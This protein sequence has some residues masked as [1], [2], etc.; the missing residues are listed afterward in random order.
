[1]SLYDYAGGDPVNYLD[2][3]G[4]LVAK[5]AGM[6]I[7]MHESML[8]DGVD[9]VAGASQLSAI[10]RALQNPF[11]I[12]GLGET[13]GGIGQVRDEANAAITSGADRLGNAIG[14]DIYSD[15]AAYVGAGTHVATAIAS[16]VAPVAAEAKAAGGLGNL[17]GNVTKGLSGFLTGVFGGGGVKP[18]PIPATPPPLPSVAAKEG[19]QIFRVVN[20]VE[21]KSIQNSGKFEFLPTGS[22]PTGQPG[23]FFWSSADEAAQFQQYWYRGGENSQV[24]STTIGGQ[25]KPSLFPN[26]DGIGTAIW[27]DLKDLSAPI[28]LPK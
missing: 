12:P 24:I 15:E 16:V 8:Q 21:L 11:L 22:T 23:K 10:A 9:M 17:W 26:T 2:P 4:R 13:L 7:R 28:I 14:A 5:Q 6:S 18:P 1:M 3:D 25:V 19:Q 20:D 27:V